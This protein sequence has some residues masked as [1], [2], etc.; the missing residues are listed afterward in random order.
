VP[1][2]SPIGVA[3]RRVLDQ[4][5]DRERGKSILDRDSLLVFVSTVCRQCPSGE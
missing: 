3:R 1:T 4:H 5:C 2:A